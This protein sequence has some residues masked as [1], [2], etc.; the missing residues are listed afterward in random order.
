M[1]VVVDANIIFS[2]I[3]NTKGKIGDLLINSYPTIKFIA[4]DFLRQE[5]KK[6]H[7]KLSQLSGLRIEEIKESEYQ[8]CKDVTF[9][10]EELI[11]ED[12]WKKAFDLV[13]DIDPKDIHYVAYSLH[14]KSKIWSGDK[15]LAKGLIKKGF[16]NILTTD[17]LLKERERIK[18]TRKSR[19]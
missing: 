8:I 10:S 13:G 2:A 15:A 5:I 4:P 6:Y 14:F 3:L 17:E 12:N 7:K 18:L 16:T 11:A 19:R 9:L 1:K